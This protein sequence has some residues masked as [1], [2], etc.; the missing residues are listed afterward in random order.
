MLSNR[1]ARA[2]RRELRHGRQIGCCLS[3]TRCGWIDLEKL[4]GFELGW[5]HQV[6]GQRWLRVVLGRLPHGSVRVIGCIRR[7]M[8]GAFAGEAALLMHGAQLV[9]AHGDGTRVAVAHRIGDNAWRPLRSFAGP[10]RIRIPI[11]VEGYGVHANPASSGRVR[12]HDRVEDPPVSIRALH[13]GAVAGAADDAVV[14][15][16]RGFRRYVNGPSGLFEE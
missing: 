12:H 2:P 9:D 11:G 7:F 8:T 15:L 13:Y 3:R 6:D 16:R 4:I 14:F 5:S 10:A 1:W